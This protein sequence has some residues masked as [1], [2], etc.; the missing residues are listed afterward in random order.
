MTATGTAACFAIPYIILDTNS[1]MTLN[2]TQRLEGPALA[3]RTR[4]SQSHGRTEADKYAD[5]VLVQV[6]QPANP[7]GVVA[8]LAARFRLPLVADVP[9]RTPGPR[10]SCAGRSQPMM[11]SWP[12]TCPAPASPQGEHQ[13][14]GIESKEHMQ[15]RGQASPDDRDASVSLSRLL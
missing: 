7:L 15:K 12:P 9:D 5:L 4:W 8:Q 1:S 3:L 11:R 13:P 14:T 2:F 6:M 10:G